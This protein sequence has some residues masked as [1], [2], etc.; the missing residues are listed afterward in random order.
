MKHITKQDTRKLD[1]KTKYE[2]RQQIIRLKREGVKAEEIS[3]ITGYGVVQISRIYQGY[4]KYGLDF[5]KPRPLGRPEGS[6]RLS[7][8]EEKEVREIVGSTR[9]FTQRGVKRFYFWCPEALKVFLLLNYRIRVSIATCRKYLDDWSYADKRPR[10][11]SLWKTENCNG[12]KNFWRTRQRAESE[13]F[14]L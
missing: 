12:S 3:E 7:S 13:I 11:W 10:Q 8:W 4:L 14:L 2:L 9:P 5:I 1:R 6:C